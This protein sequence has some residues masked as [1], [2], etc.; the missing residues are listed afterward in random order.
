MAGRMAVQL[1]GQ[2]R[3]SEASDGEMFAASLAA[4]MAG[5]P[6]VVL[7]HVCHPAKGI[8]SQ[9]NFVPSVFELR[10]ACIS[11]MN[12]LLSRWKLAQIPPERRALTND[13][14][15]RQ[16][17]EERERRAVAERD[18][19]K[20]ETF[21]EFKARHG[22][23]NWGLTAIDDYALKRKDGY[24]VP[25]VDEIVAHYGKLKRSTPL[26]DNGKGSDDEQD[27][28]EKRVMADADA[29]C[30]A[31]REGRADPQGGEFAQ[32]GGGDAPE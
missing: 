6:P 18:K 25:T 30:G 15:R 4:V 31:G 10:E 14:I 2:F 24:K 3:I 26:P 19:T 1:L 23:D 5:F 27:N 13:S 29:A 22:G 20:N 11:H 28:Q 17:E 7:E 16:E 32:G 9:Q 21:A 8:A 12:L